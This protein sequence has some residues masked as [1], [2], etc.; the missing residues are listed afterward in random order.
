MATFQWPILYTIN[1]RNLRLQSRNMGYFQVRYDSRVIH[2]DCRGFI[3]LATGIRQTIGPM[4]LCF[5]FYQRAP[6]SGS[7]LCERTPRNYKMV[8]FFGCGCISSKKL[9]MT[10][11]SFYEGTFLL[12][13]DCSIAER[14]K[15]M[16]KQIYLA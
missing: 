7:M 3:K 9:K 8:Q 13:R 5:S 14:T 11:R 4:R 10:Q 2:Y 6:W 16:L 15:A 12:Y 1:A